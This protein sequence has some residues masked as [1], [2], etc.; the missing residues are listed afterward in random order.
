MY[1]VTG[2]CDHEHEW[3]C[4]SCSALDRLC[5]A[6]GDLVNQLRQRETEEDAELASMTACLQRVGGQIFRY[7]KHAAR[8][9]WQ[10][11]RIADTMIESVNN[12][13][14]KK[15]VIFVDLDHK[16]KI[17]GCVES[18]TFFRCVTDCEIWVL[19]QEKT[20]RESNGIFRQS[21]HVAARGNGDVSPKT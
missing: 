5:D 21:G 18:T 3:S 1:F 6:I 13:V 17:L 2:Q 14:T 4:G 11:A 12:P 9:V 7:V 8:G 19:L 10:H 16:Q 15:S 20:C